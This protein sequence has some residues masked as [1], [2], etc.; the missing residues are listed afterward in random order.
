[1]QRGALQDGTYTVLVAEH[2]RSGWSD[3]ATARAWFGLVECHGGV[4]VGEMPGGLALAFRSA[5]DAVRCAV[6]IQQA[7]QSAS[8]LALGVHAGEFRAADG[9]EAAAVQQAARLARFASP[10]Q[11]L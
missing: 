4:E 11:V 6:A 7:Q 8:E 5:G 3:R 9:T 2:R 10:G 1:M